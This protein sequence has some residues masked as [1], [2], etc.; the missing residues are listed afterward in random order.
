MW[1]ILI[2][3]WDIFKY[4]IK[5]VIKFIINAIEIIKYVIKNFMIDVTLAL[6]CTIT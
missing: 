1:Q 6:K 5:N 2:N 4:T 3:K